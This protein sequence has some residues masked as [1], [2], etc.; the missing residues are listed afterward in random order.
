MSEPFKT[1]P[2]CAYCWHRMVDLIRDKNLVINGYQASFKDTG[3]G[4]FLFTHTVDGCGTTFSIP[5]RALKK[6]YDGP[7]YTIHMALTER[8]KGHCLNDIDLEPC[9]V[10]CDMKWARDIIQV[11]KNHGPEEVLKKLEEVPASNVDDLK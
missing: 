1:C 3:E 7:E 2:R 5:A 9:S 6:L 8:C 4:L 10:E 11:L